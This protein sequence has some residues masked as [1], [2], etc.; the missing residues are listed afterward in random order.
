[1]QSKEMKNKVLELQ[2]YRDSLKDQIDGG[3]L[4]IFQ[5][6]LN[7]A[8]SIIEQLGEEKYKLWSKNLD[9]EEKIEAYENS[10]KIALKDSWSDE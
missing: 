6:K 3:A 9:L 4:V 7:L 2:K 1:M 8:I 5:G 10:M